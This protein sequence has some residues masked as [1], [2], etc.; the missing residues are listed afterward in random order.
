MRVAAE[1]LNAAKRGHGLPLK[2]LKRFS[3]LMGELSN[4]KIRCPQDFLTDE[5]NRGTTACMRVLTTYYS[6][7]LRAVQGK[8]CWVVGKYEQEENWPERGRTKNTQRCVSIFLFVLQL[9][10]L[11]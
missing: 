5:P 10:A 3:V 2:R 4:F 8:R 6:I 11:R 7:A 9:T 1:R